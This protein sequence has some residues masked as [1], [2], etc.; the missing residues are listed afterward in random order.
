[1]EKMVDLNRQI[2]LFN[3]EQFMNQI[4]LYKLK[5]RGVAS[6]HDPIPMFHTWG[7]VL[8]AQVAKVEGDGEGPYDAPH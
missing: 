3:N 4:D 1:M 2:V 6:T 7:K 5:N 8:Q